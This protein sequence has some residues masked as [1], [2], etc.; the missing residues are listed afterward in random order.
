M[1]KIIIASAL[2][3]LTSC[4]LLN[5]ATYNAN[6]HLIVNTIRTV[7]ELSEDTCNDRFKMTPVAEK[8]YFLSTELYNFN[9]LVPYNEEAIN[10][11]KTL[12][13]VTKGFHQRYQSEDNISIE[14]CKIKLKTIHDASKA[15]EYV[16]VRKPK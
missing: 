4:S 12:V 5:M 3:L 11:S 15:I 7:A 16:I 1:K 13:D 10:M 8:L 14:Y 6:E 2:L 9:S